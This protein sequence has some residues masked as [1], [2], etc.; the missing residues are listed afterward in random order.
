MAGRSSLVESGVGLVKTISVSPGLRVKVSDVDYKRVSEH[1]WCKCASQG[2]RFYIHSFIHGKYVYLHRFIRNAKSGELID[3]R[4]HDYLNY[5][6]SNLRRCNNSQNL[7]NSRKSAS[8]NHKSKG[9]YFRK[10][11]IKTPWTAEITTNYKHIHLGYFKTEKLAARAYAK[12]AR[13]FHGNFA[14]SE[15]RK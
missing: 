8:A 9:V 1:S 10:D 14:F 11:L 15:S 4:H 2:D 6:R 12:A 13:K 7:A 3:H 5:M